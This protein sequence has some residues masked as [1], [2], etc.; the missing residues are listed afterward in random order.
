IWH[1][2]T[3]SAGDQVAQLEAYRLGVFHYAPILTIDRIYGPVAAQ[4]AE[5]LGRPVHLK[6]K[7]TFDKFAEELR[8]ETYD[9]I[10]VHPFFYV[11]ARDRHHYV[12]L[13]RLEEPLTAM[14]MVREDDPLATLAD[15]KGKTIGLPPARAAVSELV[16]AS[17]LDAGLVPGINVALQHYR[18]K[19][20]CLQAVAIG[21]AAACGLPRF[22][23]AQIDPDNQ[24][25]LRLIFETGPV[26]NF[27]F[28]AH[29]RVPESDRINIYKSILAWPFTATG[30]RILAGGAW[31]RFVAARDQDYDEIRRH[32]LRLQSYVRR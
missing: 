17:L 14:V 27:V 30:R 26:S 23:L 21:R 31:S 32:L 5:D 8:K 29:A 15:L 7:P 16:K 3:A 12:P 11:E 20:S 9:I 2:P 19:P 10:L 22:A 25:K 13:A 28:A 18:T 4:F 1:L 24:L 6:T